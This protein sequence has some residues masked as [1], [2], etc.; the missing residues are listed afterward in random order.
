MFNPDG[1]EIRRDSDNAIDE[2]CA[3][4]AYVH[5][6]RM[7]DNFVWMAVNDTHVWLTSENSIKIGCF[8]NENRINDKNVN[9]LREVLADLEHEQWSHW[10]K[11]MLDNLTPKNIER[12]KRQIETPYSQLTE[13]EKDSDREWA[14]KVL[15]LFE[16]REDEK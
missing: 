6:E 14:D 7:D 4:D 11:H 9:S 15:S 2:V 10:T 8:D 16:V 5:L 1:V 3:K 13:K 12:W